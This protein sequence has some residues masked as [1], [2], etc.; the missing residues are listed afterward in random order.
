MNG[1]C[2]VCNPLTPPPPPHH[3]PPPRTFCVPQQDD[4]ITHGAPPA[5]SGSE[6]EYLSLSHVQHE[7]FHSFQRRR[8]PSMPAGFSLNKPEGFESHLEAVLRGQ[9]G[10]CSRTASSRGLNPPSTWLLP[11]PVSSARIKLPREGS[12]EVWDWGQYQGG[13]LCVL[14]PLWPNN[15]S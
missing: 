6:P 9:P 2:L 8:D 15:H 1:R 11:A 13:R 12:R 3:H 10:Q 7:S 14:L 4:L 5:R